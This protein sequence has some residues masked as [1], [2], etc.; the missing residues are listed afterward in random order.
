MRFHRVLLC[1][2]LVAAVSAI[3][4]PA[5]VS[6]TTQAK[7]AA[8]ERVE[9]KRGNSW[10]PA[11]VIKRDGNKALVHYEGLSNDFD[12]W[13]GPERMR[14]AAVRPQAPP[15]PEPA[16]ARKEKP[17]KN[18]ADKSDREPSEDADEDEDQPGAKVTKITRADYA[19]AKRITSDPSAAPD[20]WKLTADA[21]PSAP[22]KLT[23]GPI[24]LFHEN[25]QPGKPGRSFHEDIENPIFAG[26]GVAR[27]V[28]P[29][30][31]RMTGGEGTALRLELL[32]L[33]AGR[34]VA[35]AEMPR[36][37]KVLGLSPDGNNVLLN[38]AG[39]DED[40]NTR[41]DV[42][43][44][45]GKKAAHVISWR[46]YRD[47][48]ERTR[49]VHWAQFVD[50][51]HVLTS[52]PEGNLVLWE[53]A[54]AR[55]IYTLKVDGDPTPVLS[56]GGKYFL[57]AGHND[58]MAV[59]ESMTGKLVAAQQD[60]GLWA[61]KFQFRP[62]GKQFLSEGWGRVRVWDFE[63]GKEVADIFLPPNVGHFGTDWLANELINTGF[64]FIHNS[65]HSLACLILTK[66]FHESRS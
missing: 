40:K 29:R 28:L 21:P 27:A 59:Y 60:K 34:S 30:Y 14:E 48:E 19:G 42:F 56:P 7:A 46:P 50:N 2:F 16:P 43:S 32:D 1:G 38:Q 17:D 62:D 11:T 44:V 4:C 12:E 49:R 26:P 37:T 66:I 51:T 15:E 53:W 9:V 10:Y 39:R 45:E 65:I 5:P 22:T 47:G 36:D 64:E 35:F 61:C 24:A 57:L 54:K 13:V 52:N 23:N 3:I 41:L 8:P 33:A 6:A 55:A 58:W 25:D 63:D 31:N 18:K 20:T